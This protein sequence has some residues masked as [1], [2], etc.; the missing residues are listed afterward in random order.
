MPVP[1]NLL[2]LVLLAGVLPTQGCLPVA[3]G[4]VGYAVSSSKEE[5]AQK[6]AD[7]KNIQTYNTYKM[8]M[9]K[10]NLDRQKSKLKPQPILTFG[11]WKLAHNIPTRAPEPK[12][13]PSQ[14]E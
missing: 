3:V 5:A 6:D 7:A 4:Y 14:Q 2:S 9:E 1:R 10:L 11:E 13:E 8:D 12:K